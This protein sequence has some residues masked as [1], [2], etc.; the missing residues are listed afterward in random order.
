MRRG[1]LAVVLAASA[2]SVAGTRVTAVAVPWLVLVTTGSAAQTG[3]VAAAEL[4]PLVLAKALS[5][6]L[7]DRLGARRVSV[8]CDL[9]GAALTGLVP[10]LHVLGALHLGVLLVVMALVGAV[11]GPGDT[12][13]ATWIPELAEGTGLP[14]E[15]IAGLVGTVDRAASIVGPALAGVLIA[16]LGPANALVADAVSF[17]VCGAA[18]ALCLPRRAPV[19]VPAATSYARRLHAGWVFLRTDRL[20]LALVAMLAVTNLLDTAMSSVLLPTW[21]RTHGYGPA[22]LGLVGS[23]FGLAATAGSVAA[24]V[25]G[26]R[27]PRRAVY[28]AGFLLCGA[29]RWV[30]LAG[31]APLW[32][33]VGIS[34]A[35]GA[36]AGFLNP[37]IGAVLVERVPRG[38]L[39][40]V[41]AIAESASWAGMPLGGL[42]AGAAVVGVGLA[43]VLAVGGAVYLVTTLLPTRLPSW[44]G[45]DTRPAPRP[46]RKLQPS[47]P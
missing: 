44:R 5:G 12:A 33:V 28:L 9:A 31:G 2:V 4:A 25:L 47:A 11:R 38:L 20:L 8:A 34:V 29:P 10:L 17:A 42:V 19:A 13:K 36:G 7:I 46:G 37:V 40:R 14:L 23:A 16:A 1:A 3:L 45:L 27:L 26:E 6:P 41:T 22:A 18:I 24:A 43:P 32:A 30:V 35:G 15:R 39:G 21:I